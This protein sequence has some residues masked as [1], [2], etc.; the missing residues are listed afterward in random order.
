MALAVSESAVETTVWDMFFFQQPEF[1]Y[2]VVIALIA[3]GVLFWLF[4][5]QFHRLV[6]T[7]VA[8][9]GGMVVGWYLGDGYGVNIPLAM[10]LGAIIGAG[11]GYWLFTLWLGLLA[12]GLMS[13]V[14][15]AVFWC[16]LATSY[17]RTAA[18]ESQAELSKHGLSLRPAASQPA[19]QACTF[20]AQTPAKSGEAYRNL[21]MLLPKLSRAN[22]ENWDDWRRHLGQNLKAVFDNLG[23]IIPPFKLGISV[24]VC[25]SLICALLLAFLRTD[26]LNIVY[27]SVFGTALICAG[28]AVLLTLKPTPQTRWF[29]QNLWLIW[30]IMLT[31]TVVG[32]GL[33]YYLYPKPEEEAEEETEE[34]ETDQGKQ[35]KPGK[36]TNK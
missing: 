12:S 31:M 26:F 29:A 3:V 13:L 11:I 17:L 35:A 7:V 28:V 14:L 9:A 15:I 5:S 34:P 21:Q 8:L 33:Q 1:I 30:P 36:S 23:V 20:A 24:I 18:T 10:A 4:G 27:T 2:S 19:T 25:V 32:T 16:T 6:V 22:Y